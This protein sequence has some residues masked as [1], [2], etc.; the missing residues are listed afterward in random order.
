MSKDLDAGSKK[1]EK[2]SRANDGIASLASRRAAS[3]TAATFMALHRGDEMRKF[4]GGRGR[5]AK[6]AEQRSS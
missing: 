6:R 3:C 4:K 2:G 5:N 1:M